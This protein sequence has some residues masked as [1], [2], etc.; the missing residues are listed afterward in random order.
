MRSV[1]LKGNS[2][3]TSYD[4]F[5]EMQSSINDTDLVPPVFDSYKRITFIV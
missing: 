4:N 3:M 5:D 2:G 1:N